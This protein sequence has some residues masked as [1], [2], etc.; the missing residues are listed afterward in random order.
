MRDFVFENSTKIYFGKNS[1]EDYLITE[2]ENYGDTVLLGYGMGSIKKNGIYDIIL[3][4]LREAGKNIIDFPNIMSNPTLAKAKEGVEL[5]KDYK[6]DL[7]LAVGGGS[8]ID[9]CKAVSLM[10]RYGGNAWEDYWLKEGVIDFEPISLGTVVTMPASGSEVNGGAVITNEGSKIKTDRDYPELNPK[11][12]FLNPSYMISLSDYQIRVGGFDI[13][14]H[15]METFFSRPNED[16]TSDDI[17]IALMKGTIRS[18][19]KLSKNRNDYTASSNL[20]WNASLA[21]NRLIKMGKEKD[22]MAHNIAHQISAYTNSNHGNTLAVIQPNYYKRVYKHGISKF[23][24]FALDVWEV[25]EEGKT[26]DEIAREG[27][28]CLVNFIKSLSLKENLRSLGVKDRSLLIKIAK[29]CSI[30]KGSYKILTY[31]DILSILK[32]SY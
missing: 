10:A 12:S 18:L 3:S 25:N 9:C 7:I 4:K 28:D 29:S 16:N 31:E 6:V 26:D 32:E 17:S 5:V 2:L 1:I 23:K 19:K 11:F 20:M 15:I 27:I 13:L 8:V 24:K 21:E 30:S 14:S 22:F